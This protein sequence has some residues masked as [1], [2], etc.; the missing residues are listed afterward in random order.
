[1]DSLACCGRWSRQGSAL[2][3]EEEGLVVVLVVAWM[4]V[5]VV[6]VPD[7]QWP[8]YDELKG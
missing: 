5:M 3:E 8:V 4:V 7:A 1:M 2:R 6:Q